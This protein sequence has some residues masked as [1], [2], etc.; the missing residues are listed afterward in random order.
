MKEGMIFLFDISNTV[1]PTPIVLHTVIFPYFVSRIQID[2]SINQLQCLTKRGS[3]ICLQ[4]SSKNPKLLEPTTYIESLSCLE[5]NQYKICK[6]SWLS[7]PRESSLNG[8]YLEGSLK[9]NL[10]VRD[11]NSESEKMLKIPVDF[12]DKIKE[13]HYNS[14]KNIIFVTSRDGRLKC[15][16][17]PNKWGSKEMEDL[18]NEVEFTKKQEFMR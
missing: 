15:F 12:T 11:I 3:L 7:R 6:V 13:L 17:L 8:T 10:W 9:G 14:E 5:D 18:N 16:K 1:D 4:L 2:T